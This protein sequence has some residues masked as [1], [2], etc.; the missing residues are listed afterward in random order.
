MAWDRDTDV[1]D[2][3]RAFEPSLPGSVPVH[4]NDVFIL[5]QGIQL[6]IAFFLTQPGKATQMGSAMS[7]NNTPHTTKASCSSHHATCGHST[8]R[9]AKKVMGRNSLAG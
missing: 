3:G 2:G 7:H 8:Q 9:D 5:L 1:F 6:T 4:S